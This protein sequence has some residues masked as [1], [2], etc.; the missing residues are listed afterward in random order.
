MVRWGIERSKLVATFVIED[1]EERPFQVGFEEVE[2]LVFDTSDE[3]HQ[4][5]SELKGEGRLTEK[6]VVVMRRG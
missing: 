3:A 1:W 4:R 6:A 2:G 5:L